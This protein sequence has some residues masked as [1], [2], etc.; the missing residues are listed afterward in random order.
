MHRPLDEI[1]GQMEPGL[2]RSTLRVIS[3][4]KGIDNA[5]SRA[6]LAA[7][8]NSLGFGRD[9]TPATFDRKIRATIVELRRLGHLICS[10]S[11]EGGYYMAANRAEYDEFSLGEY[12]SK[13]VDMSTTLK[14]MDIAAD[15][16][17]G[18]LTPGG[19]GSLF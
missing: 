18:K 5:I 9:L 1:I 16:Q 13:I 17:F 3:Q 12:R 6:S 14:A 8:L 15:R 2:E 4:R 10:S 19:Q 7:A 11:G